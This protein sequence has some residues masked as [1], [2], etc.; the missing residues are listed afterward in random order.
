SQAVVDMDI[1]TMGST[2]NLYGRGGK[3]IV[4]NINNQLAIIEFDRQG[5]QIAG[6][7][8]SHI[9]DGTPVTVDSTATVVGITQNIFN[10]S[11]FDVILRQADGQGVIL[12]LNGSNQL[13]ASGNVA[14]NADGS[15][16]YTDSNTAGG[17]VINAGTG[18]GV[19]VSGN[20]QFG[21]GDS[22][23][24]SNGHVTV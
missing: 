14:F 2:A 24:I 5:Q 20:G 21:N 9:T 12:E 18:N 7:F 13:M 19:I 11:G 17:D 3:D 10:T 22:V 8:I 1:T 6:G 16:T 4:F 23:T 15:W